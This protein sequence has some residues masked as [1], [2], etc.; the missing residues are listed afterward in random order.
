MPAR[1]QS[2][3]RCSSACAAPASAAR[4]STSCMARTPSPATRASSATSS[5]ARSRRSAPDVSGLAPGDRVVVDPV[6]S[7]GTCYACRVGRPNVCAN[8]E[9]FGVHRDG[10]FRDLVPVPARNVVKVSA[11]LPVEIA[12]LSRALLDRGQRP[13]ADRMR[14]RGH[15]PGLRRR[16]RRADG[17]AGGEAQ[18]CSLPG[19]RPRRGAPGARALLRR[20]RGD[21]PAE[22]ARGGGRRQRDGWP[23]AL[24]W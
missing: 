7:C 19:Q 6:V 16:H 24:R 9:V 13:L 3:A 4:T 22:H 23:R 21:Q 18:G 1:R 17:A 14:T 5:P 10:G 8:L 15:R 20:R 2:V 11:D 12:A